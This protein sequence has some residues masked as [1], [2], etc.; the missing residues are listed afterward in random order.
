LRRRQLTAHSVRRREL[1]LDLDALGNIGDLIGG[2][3]VVVTLA[4]LVFQLRQN[5]AQL[6]QHSELLTASIAAS[7]REATDASIAL[8]AGDREVARIF[9]AGIR[10]REALEELDRQ[11][12]DPLITMIFNGFLQSYRHSDE[13]G[14]E[15]V[16]WLLSQPGIR[17]WWG[18]FSMTYPPDY[19]EY[20]D[21]RI[22]AFTASAHQSVAAGSA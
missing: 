13:P 3:G 5:T 22:E 12:F 1:K 4:F 7:S 15:R 17:Q 10:D 9:W 20:V 2:V 11:Q 6:R 16:D 19:R 14:L 21:A 8:L 18:E